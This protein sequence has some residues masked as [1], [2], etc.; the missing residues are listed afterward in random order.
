MLDWI[1]A[2][3]AAVRATWRG[4]AE[5]PRWPLTQWP[6]GIVLAGVG[7]SGMAGRAAE[8]LLCDLAPVPVVWM[9]GLELPAWLSS[10]GLLVICS[11]SGET[12][13]ALQVAE[14]ARARG[15]P[16]CAVAAGGPLTERAVAEGAPSIRLEP[17]RAPRAMTAAAVAA[18]LALGARLLPQLDAA[19]A[20]SVQGMEQDL[21]EWD[22]VRAAPGPAEAWEEAGAW[23]QLPRNPRRLSALLAKRLPIFYGWGSA[24]E[25]VALRWAAQL[26]ENAKTAAHAHRLPEALHNEI[27]AWASWSAVNPRP[28]IVR[29]ATGVS[30]G[31]HD[32]AV[33]A[34]WK[35]VADEMARAGLEGGLLPAPAGER[36]AVLLR[37]FLLADAA[38]VLLALRRGEAVTPVR[39]IERLK[40]AAPE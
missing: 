22:L 16:W 1:V 32:A 26:A 15:I 40:G 33:Q 14:E 30:S 27:V 7:G 35:R 12:W 18:L 34:W 29:L 31:K 9:R 2:T 24:G 10:G 17:G 5:D 39:P 13:E 28:F 36:V 6:P 37:Q 38:S 23:P 25:A 11:Y 8:A 19:I 3:P 20:E 21:A 4:A